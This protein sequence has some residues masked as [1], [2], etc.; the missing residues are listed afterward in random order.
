ME[1]NDGEGSREAKSANFNFSSDGETGSGK[2]IGR[3]ISND[4]SADRNERDKEQIGK[5]GQN[6]PAIDAF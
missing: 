1:L 5:R 6:H 3:A 4:G 2:R